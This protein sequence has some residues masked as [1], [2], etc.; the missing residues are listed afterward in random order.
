MHRIIF[1]IAQTVVDPSRINVPKTPAEAPQL[2]EIL[3][4]VFALAGAIS[5][6]VVT[7]AGLSYVLSTGDPQKTARAK[8]AILY[9]LI[10]LAVS[11][12]SFTIVTFVIGRLF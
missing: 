3:Q 8:D 11:I 5:V 9:A 12:L 6:L 10:G 1:L 4:V 7:V 2:Q